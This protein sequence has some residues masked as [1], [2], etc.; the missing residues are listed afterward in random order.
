MIRPLTIVLSLIVALTGP[1]A[2]I[3]AQSSPTTA[4]ADD[5]LARRHLGTALE[6]LSHGNPRAAAEEVRSAAKSVDVESVAVKLRSIAGELERNAPNDGRDTGKALAAAAIDLAR[7]RNARTRR[8]LESDDYN[9]AGRHLDSAAGWLKDAV[10]WSGEDSPPKELVTF[11]GNAERVAGELRKDTG[12]KQLAE[13]D[14]AAPAAERQ[15][16]PPDPITGT[17]TT[18]AETKNVAQEAMKI[19]DELA[20]RI[21]EFASKIADGA[22]NPA[23]P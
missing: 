17:G 18:D 21:D 1:G 2:A 9:N 15:P 14:A 20:K 7:D 16:P 5:G 22:P 4:P 13:G 11:I 8:A 3:R 19:S 6:K 23:K 10:A 12:D